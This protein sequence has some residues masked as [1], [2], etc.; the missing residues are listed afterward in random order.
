M[1]RKLFA[2]VLGA[3]MS[4]LLTAVAIFMVVLALA[5]A[6]KGAPAWSYK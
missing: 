4:C 6:L 2:P 3:T 1:I 5:M